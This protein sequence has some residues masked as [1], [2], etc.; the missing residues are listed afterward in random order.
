MPR[1]PLWDRPL[2]SWFL[3]GSPRSLGGFVGRLRPPGDNG[4]L[5]AGT[6][7][8]RRHRVQGALGKCPWDKGKC[9][10]GSAAVQVGGTGTW[11]PEPE[12]HGA[13]RWCPQG[14]CRSAAGWTDDPE[15]PGALRFDVVLRPE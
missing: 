1:L 10:D 3:L 11:P 6:D 2:Q 13:R 14:I 7:Q 5:P 15:V 4:N 8:P 9:Q 12:S